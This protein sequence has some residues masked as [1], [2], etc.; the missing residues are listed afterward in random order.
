MSPLEVAGDE[1]GQQAEPAPLYLASFEKLP[2]TIRL[3]GGEEREVEF[4]GEVLLAESGQGQEAVV[5]QIR[6]VSLWIDSLDEAG[7][8]ISFAGPANAIRLEP[9]QRGQIE[10]FDVQFYYPLL[11]TEPECE[12]SDASYV[13]LEKLR[14]QLSYE[15]GAAEDTKQE[16]RITI[17]QQELIQAVVGAVEGFTFDHPLIFERLQ[18]GEYTPPDHNS[19]VSC[20]GSAPAGALHE[21]RKLKLR[22]V[23][24]SLVASSPSLEPLVQDLLVK[25]CQVWWAKGGILLEPEAAI[26]SAAPAGFGCAA[27]FCVSLAQE[28]ML[29]GTSAVKNAAE[30]YLV[31][32]LD[33]T[34]GGGVT[35][36]CGTSGA[37]VILE[38]G[39]AQNNRYLLAHELGHVLGL[40]HPAEAA[41]AASDPCQSYRAGSFCS[42]MVA[43]STNS[44]RNTDLNIGVTVEPLNPLPSGP[45]FTSLAQLGDWAFDGE[46]GFFHI[47]RDFPYDDGAEDSTPL[48]PFFTN[49]WACS[50]V[51]N[52]DKLPFI[53]VWPDFLYQGGPL[54]LG[55]P[56]FAADHSPIHS[57]PSVA[58]PNYFYVRLH[59]CQPLNDPAIDEVRV[60]LLLAVP[61]SGGALIPAPAAPGFS[62]P[63]VFSRNL[64]TLPAPS[65]P[66]VKHMQWTVP[67]GLP[68]DCCVFAVA[69]S[70]F[71]DLPGGIAPAAIAA[72][73]TI[74]AA[75][76]S[77]S[78]F[79][80]FSRLVSSNNV[81]QRNLHIHGIA[82]TPGA[83]FW[84]TLPWLL[85]ANPFP[86]PAAARLVIDTRSVRDLGLL[87]L[88]LEVNDAPWNDV[89]LGE[90]VAFDLREAL[91][92][93]EDMTLRLQAEVAPD[94]PL[95]ARIPID[96]QFFL[97]GEQISGFQHVIQ[98]VTAEEAAAQALD[99]LCCA[100]RD[101]GAAGQSERA[102]ALA[103][104]VSR[105]RA[106]QLRM[107]RLD[108]ARLQSSLRLL[109]T[110]LAVL[111]QQLEPGNNRRSPLSLVARR[112]RELSGYLLSSRQAG[113]LP[114][115]LEGL[116][117]LADRIQEPASRIVRRQQ[118]WD[119][120]K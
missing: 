118:G 46:Q 109:A 97:A 53:T 18:P 105:S 3:R 48:A 96:L 30:V 59:T 29:Q 70:Q 75:P 66:Q 108:T 11:P 37:Y 35:K 115:Y 19:L 94:L 38:I 86:E 1:P 114:S 16:V 111:V 117:D 33:P 107:A 81:V 98:V 73:R 43:D 80:L 77:F 57:E 60:H 63:L 2:G 40:R 15:I 13:Q 103:Q 9:G 41:P 119:R 25:A 120:P 99:L 65:R 5:E 45:I 89:P 74:V 12:E 23:N 76:G 64:G 95:G 67:T 6:R 116:R 47:L 39:Q 36:N 34:R 14:G 50:D 10:P 88:I 92:P 85:F 58:G 106:W 104:R 20:A 91:S 26:A 93:R 31:D 32:G 72:L 101:V 24:L 68:P 83:P 71:E 42:V 55:L 51:W 21:R 44:S 102:M 90:V 78:F 52:S 49:W 82:P 100:L 27:G 22:F 56:M 87:S 8:L 7:G 17:E 84:A 112:L 113:D 54:G 79:D 69:D 28:S 110:E 61:G 62:N 4:S